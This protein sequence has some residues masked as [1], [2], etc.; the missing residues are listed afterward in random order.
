MEKIEEFLKILWACF[1]IN[2]EFSQKDKKFI[3]V[4]MD[5]EYYNDIIWGMDD[6]FEWMLNFIM[7]DNLNILDA[8][9][10]YYYDYISTDNPSFT[11]KLIN[12]AKK[13]CT[14]DGTL[15]SDCFEQYYNKIAEYIYEKYEDIYEFYNYNHD[16]NVTVIMNEQEKEIV[17]TSLS[18]KISSSLLEQY[19]KFLRALISELFYNFEDTDKTKNSILSILLLENPN[20]F[21]HIKKRE[22]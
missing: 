16:Y 4:I 1:K 6:N 5:L 10:S 3:S 22:F 21:E 12:E 14:K 11:K 15:N 17:F 7:E 9:N 20:Y 18:K 2:Y 13:K 19:P 8:L